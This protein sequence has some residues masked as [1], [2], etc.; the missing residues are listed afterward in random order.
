MPETNTDATK[1]PDTPKPGST[2]T[3]IDTT[4]KQLPTVDPAL[5]PD[6]STKPTKPTKK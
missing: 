2:S 4:D 1:S 5:S 6:T 3:T